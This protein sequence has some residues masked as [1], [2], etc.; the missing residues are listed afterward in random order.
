M[1]ILADQRAIR[2]IRNGAMASAKARAR[3][4]AK[5]RACA[6]VNNDDLCHEET[7]K[8]SNGSS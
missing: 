7:L 3:A 2:R 4:R 5:I 6:E 1:N 8:V